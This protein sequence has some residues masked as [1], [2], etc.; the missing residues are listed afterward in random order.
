MKSSLWIVI[1]VTAAFLG[2]MMGY[3]L[4]PM[5]EAGVFAGKGEPAGIEPG[6]DKEMEQYYQELMKE[7]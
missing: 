7:E 4:P 6:L 3:S 2:F 5:I 1:A